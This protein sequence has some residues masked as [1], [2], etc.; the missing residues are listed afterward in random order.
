MVNCEIVK[1]NKCHLCEQ[2]KDMK[3]GIFVLNYFYCSE[4]HTAYCLLHPD[5]IK[6][7]D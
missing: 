2:I 1:K 5:E 3:T 6:T 4:C 7:N